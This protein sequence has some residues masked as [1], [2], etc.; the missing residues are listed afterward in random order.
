MTY[1]GMTIGELRDILKNLDDDTSINISVR[2]SDESTRFSVTLRRTTSVGY[3][4]ELVG[5]F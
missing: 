1:K 2:N 4:F 5:Y 3:R